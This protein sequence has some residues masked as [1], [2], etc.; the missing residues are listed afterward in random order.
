[1]DLHVFSILNFPLTS[2]PIPSLWVILK[3]G[4]LLTISF[5]FRPIIIE[6]LSQKT[7]SFMEVSFDSENC[8]QCKSPLIDGSLNKIW[9]LPVMRKLCSN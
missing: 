5:F 8:N 1:M 3:C 7:E 6:K 2:L 4:Y 9:Y